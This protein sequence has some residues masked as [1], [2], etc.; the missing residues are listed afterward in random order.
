VLAGVLVGV[1]YFPGP[2]LPLNLAGFVP[3]LMWLESRPAATPYERLKAGFA[4]GLT[5]HLVSL[6]FM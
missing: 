3:L 4:F 5:A 1:G 2:F 6:H